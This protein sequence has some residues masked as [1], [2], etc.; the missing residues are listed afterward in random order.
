MQPAG[1]QALEPVTPP[2]HKQLPC[3]DGAFAE[4]FLEHPQ[5]NLLTECLTPRLRELHPDGQFCIGC[6]SGF[7][8]RWTEPVLAGCKAPDWFLV[9][10]VPPMLDGEVRRSYVLW[11]ESLKPLV[12]MEFV[13]GDGGEERDATPYQGKFWVYEQGISAAFYVIYD[14]KTPSVEVFR[15]EMGRYQPTDANARG[16]FPIPPLGVEL[17]L[18]QGTYRG[19][20]VPWLRAW[21][22]HT[23]DMLPLAE[24]RA[25]AAEHLLVDARQD[26]ADET[27]R[28]ETERK[29]AD[30][31]ERKAER[32]AARLGELGLAPEDG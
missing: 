4:T 22:A 1:K 25:E 8:W 13:S 17:G 12:V 2:D 23:G 31:A 16:R 18:W 29:R 3:E 21:D 10:G 20:T 7:Y 19:M 9:V 15:L 11:R 5:S 6:D 28:A 27:E 32:L 14:V 26:L 24:E 30:E